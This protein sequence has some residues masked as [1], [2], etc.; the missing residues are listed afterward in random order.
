MTYTYMVAP[1]TAK[2]SHP[3][4]RYVGIY[5]VLKN[6]YH[7]GILYV[8]KEVVFCENRGHAKRLE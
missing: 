7:A 4:P 1:V 2:G 5:C 3:L 8:V 6:I